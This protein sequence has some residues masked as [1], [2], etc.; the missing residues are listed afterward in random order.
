LVYRV[1]INDSCNNVA[2]FVS[3]AVTSHGVIVVVRRSENYSNIR[4]T[5]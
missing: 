3:H 1:Y 2:T 4:D 5:F